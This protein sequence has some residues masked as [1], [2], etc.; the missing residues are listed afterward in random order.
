MRCFHRHQTVLFCRHCW[1]EM[2]DL[3]LPNNYSLLKR[4]SLEHFA[5][6]SITSHLVLAS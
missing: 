6:P 4:R 3:A 5:Q 2:P 1:Q